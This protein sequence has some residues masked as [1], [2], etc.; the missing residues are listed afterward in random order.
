[1]YLV[2][3][4]IA[5]K[6]VAVKQRRA[7]STA[8][9]VGALG[10]VY[11]DIG[12]SPLYAINATFFGIG[13]TPVTHDN[14]LGVISI[15]F[16]LLTLI[17][18]VKYITF[19][20]RASY[21]GE[22]GVLALRELVGTVK[23]AK[24]KPIILMLL[25]FG[26]TLLLGDGIITPSISVLSAVEGLKVATPFFTP[27]TVIIAA[28]IIIGLFSIQKRGT[29]QIGKI[30]GPLMIIWFFTIGMLGLIQIVHH[31]GILAA[32]NPI[33]GL[34]FIA[35]MGIGKFLIATG[36]IVLV[37]TGAEDLY[38]D[39]GH[40]GRR[41]IRLGWFYLA[42]WS[43]VLNYFGQGAYLLGGHEAV[44]DNIFFSLV[45][46]ISL[47][48]DIANAWPAWVSEFV[49]HI[50]VYSVVLLAMAATVIASQ[51]LITGVFS[52]TSQA[53]ALDMLPRLNIVH[54]SRKHRGQIYLPA[55][56]WML[57]AGCLT[58]IFIFKSSG[59]LT[60]AYGLAVSGVMLTT[61]M[62]MFF[63]ARHKWKW[64]RTATVLVFGVFFVIDATLLLATS[65]KFMTGGYIPVFV[66]VSIFTIVI[67][68]NWGRDLVRGAYVSYLEYASPRNMEWLVE[69]KRRLT[70]DREYVEETRQRKYVEL[71]RAVMFLV[72]KPVKHRTENIP[73]ILRI[74]MK[75]H[76]AIPKY[77]V[78]LT[79]V[80]EK[81]PYVSDDRRIKVI[82]FDENILSVQAHY[83]FMQSPNGLEVLKQLKTE[84]YM[85]RSLHR[86]TVEAAEEELFLTKGARFI[87]KLRIRVYLLFKSISPEAYHYFRLDA[88]PG[89]SKTIIPIVLGKNG[90][91]IE[92]PEFALEDSDEAIDPDTLMPTSIQFARKRVD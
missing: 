36:A 61:T 60:D 81:K 46:H 21:Q 13:R 66:A 74:F 56:N 49:T 70:H 5:T 55:V 78:L 41:P 8:L 69:A 11:G 57:M 12:T 90:W 92:I 4:T 27:Y 75:R 73:I 50:P 37:A 45:P 58:L 72:S 16:W 38:V 23:K 88:K 43:L 42:Y 40:F 32:L 15:I 20:L 51:A 2:R 34:E 29:A 44:G 33:Y 52:L 7:L 22:G 64:S 83:G 3:K 86:C 71:D 53:M 31:P 76:G 89:M 47:L 6:K 84:G 59:N 35:N 14:I 26:A 39:L 77:I 25:V 54:T 80:Q 48:P 82:D 91:R 30:F 17:I 10:V 18:T 65:L 1:M 87:D 19:V 79:I 28:I 67:A 68:W 9:V 24:G 62:A 85:G 63:V